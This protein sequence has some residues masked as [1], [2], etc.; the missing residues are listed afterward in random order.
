M[1]NFLA[2]KDNSQPTLSEKESLCSAI[3]QIYFGGG[4]FHCD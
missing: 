4:G 1:R 3:C 2:G